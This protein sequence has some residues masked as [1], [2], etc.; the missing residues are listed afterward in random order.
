MFRLAVI[1]SVVSVAVLWLLAGVAE[2][3]GP[4]EMVISGGGLSGQ[5]VVPVA[6][7]ERMISA[8][9]GL[10][11]GDG[12]ARPAPQ[13]SP[14]PGYSV[15][16]YIV[17]Q[18]GARTLFASFVYFP[19]TTGREALVQDPNASVEQSWSAPDPAYAALVDQYIAS[20]P[21]AF[22]ATGGPPARDSA[23]PLWYIAPCLALA[24][25]LVGGVAGRILV[26]RRN[27]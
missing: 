16:L 25:V 14:A 22:P 19:A 3:K 4:F 6:E 24:V 2:A 27:A 23:S 15:D 26:A 18:D 20:A 17:E 11:P 5:V 8:G 1:V 9:R 10:F 21:R 7:T 13:T 12:P